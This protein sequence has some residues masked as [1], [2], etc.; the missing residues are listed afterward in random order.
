[1]KKIYKSVRK[2]LGYPHL[3]LEDIEKI[4]EI[5][6]E[7]YKIESSNYEYENIEDL[8]SRYS[9][10]SD[11]TIR[12]SSPYISVSFSSNSA[13]VYIS[14]DNEE[15]LG[16]M[17]K[18]IEAVS[19]RDRKLLKVLNGILSYGSGSL[20]LPSIYLILKQ[21]NISRVA[22]IVFFL[23]SVLLSIRFFSKGTVFNHSI[24]EL[25]YYK[26]RDSMFDRNTILWLIGTLITVGLSII[27]WIYFSK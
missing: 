27:G 3:Y 1:M 6:G 12:S 4:I 26:D 24:S 5:V 22:G 21:S 7:S 10:I 23:I 9:K 25:N 11:L 15:S 16:K 17:Q 8:K 20:F 18:I 14:D 2:Y 13:D 19:K